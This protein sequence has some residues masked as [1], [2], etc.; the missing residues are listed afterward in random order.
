[1]ET[2]NLVMV[3]V[4]VAT[5]V[6]EVLARAV[7]T[8]QNWSGTAMVLRVLNFLSDLLNNKKTKK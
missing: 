1:M 2:T 3:I 6:W 8:V 7:P 4:A 5:G